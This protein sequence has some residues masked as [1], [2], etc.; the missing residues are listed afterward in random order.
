[1][2][3][4]FGGE[5]TGKTF[6]ARALFSAITS[7]QDYVHQGE[8]NLGYGHEINYLKKQC[9]CL[10]EPTRSG[11]ISKD[12]ESKLK[13]I[14]DAEFLTVNQKG[15]DQYQVRNRALFW[16][17]SNEHYLPVSGAARRWLMIAAAIEKNEPLIKSA[18]DWLNSESNVGGKIR[19]WLKDRY[20]EVSAHMLTLEAD[21]LDS[22]KQIVS[23]N[24]APALVEY[25]SV[26]EEL[27]EE[28]I[29]LGCIPTRLLYM[30]APYNSKSP[31]EIATIGRVLSIDYPTVKVGSSQDGKVRIA[32][33]ITSNFRTTKKRVQMS[34]HSHTLKEL[35]QKWESHPLLKNAY[36]PKFT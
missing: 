23:E 18:W 2:V 13:N 6:M 4:M 30:M 21:A 15:V 27:P 8:L 20:P 3:F 11:M 28:L 12:I 35:Y 5:G 16:V 29:E 22:K 34:S 17:N 33:G 7:N 36:K 26:L 10:E 9:V 1:M 14:G 24:R 25:E 31:S 19:K 32:D